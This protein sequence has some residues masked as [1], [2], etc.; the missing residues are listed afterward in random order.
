MADKPFINHI[1]TYRQHRIEQRERMFMKWRA[2]GYRDLA[3]HA[4][5]IWLSSELNRLQREYPPCLTPH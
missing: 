2:S 3:A 1:E 5:F 4:E